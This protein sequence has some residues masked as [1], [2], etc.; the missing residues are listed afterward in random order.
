[1]QM[2]EEVPDQPLSFV[3]KNTDPSQGTTFILQASTAE[4]K[5]QWLE[6]IASQ[7]DQQKAFLAALVDPKRAYQNQ[8]ANNFNSLSL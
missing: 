7:L 6:K 2:E 3:L 1:M 4:E 5:Q 8:L